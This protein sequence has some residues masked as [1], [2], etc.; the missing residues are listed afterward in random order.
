M[1]K[2]G[3][4]AAFVLLV[5]ASCGGAATD[6]VP[7]GF[8]FRVEQARQDLQGRNIEMQVV[9]GGKAPVTVTSAKFTS[10]RFAGSTTYRGPATIPEGTT[11][12]LTF[13]MPKARCGIGIDMTATVHYRVA[14]GAEHASV[15]RPKDHYGSVA[16]AMSRDCAEAAIGKLD[17]DE[18]FAVRGK[19]T[20]S[21]LKIGMTFTPN[22]DRGTVRLGPLDGTTLLKPA[23]ESGVDSVLKGTKPHRVV[24]DIIPNRCD[25][26][27]VAE[28]RTGAIMPLHVDSKASGKALFFLRF[29][30]SQRNQ[31]FDFVAAH[32]GFGTTQDPLNAP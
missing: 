1:V 5:L 16:L 25:V 23:P 12:N 3:L 29:A 27:V 13:V 30:E 4:A 10:G 24:V 20:H 11:T 26:H 19:G 21:V 8:T 22:P 6:P 15:V 31:I 7:A 28:D 17:I 14:D 32:C 2:R 9:N 18:K